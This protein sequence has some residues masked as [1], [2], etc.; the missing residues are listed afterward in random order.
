MYTLTRWTVEDYHR[1]IEAGI[2]EDRPV[3]LM[4]GEIIDMSP[5]SPFHHF[6][7]M[8]GVTYLRSLLG[9]Q[10]IISEAHPITLPDSEPEP[11]IAI[12]RLPITNYRNRHPHPEDIYWIIEISDSTLKKDLS[13]KKNVYA[14]AGIRE[15]WVI[16]LQ[17]RTL[18]VFRN[19]LGNDYE[20]AETY[21]DGVVYSLAFPTIEISVKKLLGIE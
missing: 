7:N 10:A 20:S 4:K 12:I 19:P 3:E 14:S 9:Q 6:L 1:I 21:R 18:H 2:L 15:Y 5:E 11:D 17:T 13:L 16:D 8:S